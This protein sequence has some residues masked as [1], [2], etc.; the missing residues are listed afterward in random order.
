VDHVGHSLVI[1]SWRELSMLREV[2]LQTSLSRCQLIVLL[3]ALLA[4]DIG[5]MGAMEDI[6]NAFGI[7]TTNMEPIQRSRVHMFL[8]LME[9]MKPAV[10]TLHLKLTNQER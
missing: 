3:A 2:H 1:Q 8:E 6:K 5:F 10:H 4:Q 9:E 7:G